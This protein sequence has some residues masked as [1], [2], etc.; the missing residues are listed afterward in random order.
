M[1]QFATTDSD[2]VINEVETRKKKITKYA[3]FKINEVVI[4]SVTMCVNRAAE[5][6][7]LSP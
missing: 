3:V 6:N 1:Q 5:A 7:V 2:N 4:T